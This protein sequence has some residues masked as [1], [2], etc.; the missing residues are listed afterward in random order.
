MNQ[1]HGTGYIS[2]EKLVQRGD[3]KVFD[4]NDDEKFVRDGV[5]QEVVNNII[6]QDDRSA[7]SRKDIIPRL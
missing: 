1:K 2:K 6:K 7:T 4:L 3:E 5:F